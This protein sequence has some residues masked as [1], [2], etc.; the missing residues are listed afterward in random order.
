MF[1]FSAANSDLYIGSRT[2]FGL[3]IEGQAPAI[4]KKVSK[5]GIPTNALYCCTLCCALAYTVCSTSA[6][7]VFKY[8]VSLIS[9]FGAIVSRCSTYGRG[10]RRSLSEPFLFLL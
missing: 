8:F 5:R 9:M 10:G 6:L 7:Q 3:A 1:V 2:L 4:F